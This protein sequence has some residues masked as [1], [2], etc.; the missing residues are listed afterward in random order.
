MPFSENKEPSIIAIRHGMIAIYKPAGW[1]SVFQEI[2]PKSTGALN[3]QKMADFT[4]MVSWL[5]FH[6]DILPVSELKDAAKVWQA[7]F[8]GTQA[9]GQ[10]EAASEKALNAADTFLSE[11]GMLYRLDRE[12][13]GIMLFALDRTTMESMRA[14]QSACMLK[15]R[16]ILMSKALDI[17]VPGSL[18]RSRSAEREVLLSALYEGNTVPIVSYFR[19][20]GPRGRLVSCIEPSFM[21]NADRFK[22]K[23]KIT[24]NRYQTNFL[25]AKPMQEPTADAICLEAEICKG[26][27]HQI[28]A[29]CAWMGLPIIGDVQYGGSSSRRLYLEAFSVSLMDGEQRVAEWKLH[30]GLPAIL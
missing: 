25:S 20:Y 30:D 8:A 24:K 26:F 14:A 1:H 3:Q 6:A 19:S 21:L 15:K 5:S 27:R 18:P 9:Q 2:G 10:P 12:T 29:H 7:R 17:E 11:L 13:S 22:A 16:Y 4:D 28:R 23:K